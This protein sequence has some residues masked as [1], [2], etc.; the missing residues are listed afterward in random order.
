MYCLICHQK[1]IYHHTWNSM[2]SPLSQICEECSI[3]LEPIQAPICE[4]C[5]RPFKEPSICND[6]LNWQRDPQYEKSLA[7]NRAI[8]TYNDRMK[9]I[10]YRWKYRGDYELVHLFK[11]Y[12]SEKFP[13]FYPNTKIPL[14]PIP[15]TDERM[16][17]RGFNQAEAIAQIIRDQ[18][19][20]PI[21]HALSRKQ[22]SH[23]KQSKKSKIQRIQAD[24][25]FKLKIS[26]NKP[27]IIVDDIYTTGTTIHH[28]AK[29]LKEAGSPAVYSLTMIR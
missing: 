3:Q 16:Y 22:N 2:L 24:N 9:D 29:R 8:F 12:I 26:I 7:F 21:V 20:N 27:I 11:P 19:H 23:E 18:F 10:V 13:Q 25:P 28:A 6:C 5:G 1:I 4:R 15:L 17:E 14:V